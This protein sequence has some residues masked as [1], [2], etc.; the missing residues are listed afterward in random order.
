MI[1]NGFYFDGIN[2]RNTYGYL[3]MFQ[4]SDLMIFDEK[5]AM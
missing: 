1:I 3:I 2:G 5:I 4:I